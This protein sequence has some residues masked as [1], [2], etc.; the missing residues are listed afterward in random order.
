MAFVFTL[1]TSSSCLHAT[2]RTAVQTSQNP[3]HCHLSHLSSLEVQTHFLL[4]VQLT[5][6]NNDYFCKKRAENFR[7]YYMYIAIFLFHFMW[8]EGIYIGSARSKNEN[9]LNMCRMNERTKRTNLQAIFQSEMSTT[10]KTLSRNKLTLVY[11]IFGSFLIFQT[12]NKDCCFVRFILRQ[13]ISRA[14]F[15][16]L[17]RHIGRQGLVLTWKYIWIWHSLRNA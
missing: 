4:Q 15:A 8:K 9:R 17:G 12:L 13:M 2:V 14:G 11:A 3:L 5:D 1:N 6:V 10:V 7:L 16:C